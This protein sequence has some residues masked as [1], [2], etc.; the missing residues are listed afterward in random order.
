[1][2]RRDIFSHVV[3]PTTKKL[4]IKDVAIHGTNK[5]IIRS[6]AFLTPGYKTFL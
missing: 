2:S 5:N 3:L 4:N 6:I 1:M